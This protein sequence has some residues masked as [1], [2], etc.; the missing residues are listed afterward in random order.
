VLLSV[1]AVFLLSF[2]RDS[3]AVVSRYSNG[4]AMETISFPDS[5]NITSYKR[6]SFFKNGNI[7]SITTYNKGVQQGKFEWYYENGVKKMEYTM[8]RGL[9]NGLLRT[10]YDNGK[11]KSEGTFTNGVEDGLWKLWTENNGF[12]VK[13]IRQGKQDSRKVEYLTNERGVMQI[14]LSKNAAD[15]E[16]GVWR[17]YDINSNLLQT[18]IFN[19]GVLNGDFMEYHP[20]GKIKAEGR[21]ANGF[22]DGIV[23]YYDHLGYLTNIKKYKKG[24]VLAVYRQ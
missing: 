17:L 6:I 19:N 8:Q 1:L 11:P 16:E 10:W 20:N 7:D 3:S 21:L 2:K 9:K 13:T 18:T 5:K 14:I 12:F 22:Y 15:K 23:L 4:A 24:Q